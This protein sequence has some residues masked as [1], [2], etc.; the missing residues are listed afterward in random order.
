MSSVAGKTYQ[1]VEDVYLVIDL[2]PSE[3]I[4][5]GG[6]RHLKTLKE[7]QGINDALKKI[8]EDEHGAKLLY[9]S[10]G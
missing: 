6:E 7:C 9:P 2:F 8:I 5:I 1:F 3:Y 4:H 10:F